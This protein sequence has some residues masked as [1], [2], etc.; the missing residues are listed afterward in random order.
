MKNLKLYINSK[1]C[2]LQPSNLSYNIT[3][4][5]TDYN[6][7]SKRT[8][9]FSYTIKLPRSKTNKQIF[10]FIDDLNVINKF[11]KNKNYECSFYCN[12]NLLIEG[13][14]ILSNWDEGYFNGY[15]TNKISGIFNLFGDKTLQDIESLP[16]I[17]FEGVMFPVVGPLSPNSRTFSTANLECLNTNLCF[18][19]FSLINA[20]KN[21]T[22]GLL[23]S[24]I[25]YQDYFRTPLIAYTNFS[26]NK[27]V[28]G[29][30]AIVNNLGLEDFRPSL[31]LNKVIEKL[32]FDIG[33]TVNIEVPE[34]DD[35]LLIPYVGKDFPD[36]NWTHLSKISV[37]NN[38]SYYN[39]ILKST[40]SIGIYNNRAYY[41]RTPLVNSRTVSLRSTSSLFNY[42]NSKIQYTD[43]A[44]NTDTI[45]EFVEP[46]LNADINDYNKL[47]LIPLNQIN[48]DFNN[49]FQFYDFPFSDYSSTGL[50]NR[51][52]GQIY[53]VPADGKYEFDIS[54][55]HSIKQSHFMDY[56]HY[57]EGPISYGQPNNPDIGVG[58]L[59]TNNY[60]IDYDKTTKGNIVNGYE[61]NTITT[62]T[63]NYIMNEKFYIQNMVLVTKN[64][65]DP[66][67]IMDSILATYKENINQGV[68]RPTKIKTIKR[69][70]NIESDNVVAFYHPMLR[71][72]Y[73]GESGQ[74]TW[75]EFLDNEKTI[76]KQDT[77]YPLT[78][79]QKLTH[80]GFG[81][82]TDILK[83][84]NNITSNYYRFITN[85]YVGI[86]PGTFL[87]PYADQVVGNSSITEQKK[88]KL[89]KMYN[90]N[91]D[92]LLGTTG[93]TGG[94]QLTWE[95][96]AAGQV[97]FK[98]NTLLEKGDQVRMY[99]ITM[100]QF[101]DVMKA[102]PIYDGYPFPYDGKPQYTT[103]G[104][105]YQDFYADE[106][107]VTKFNIKCI[108]EK[109][110]D[111][112]RLANFLPAIKQKDFIQ[113]FIKTNNLYFDIKDNNITFKKRKDFFSKI[114]QKDLT[115]NIDINRIQVSPIENFKTYKYG[116]AP[117]DNDDYKFSIMTTNPPL[118]F[119]NG[120]NIYLNNTTLDLTS[121]IFKSGF[122]T[123]YRFYFYDVIYDGRFKLSDNLIGYP[124]TKFINLTSF[125]ENGTSD[126]ALNEANLTYN[127]SPRIVEYDPSEPFSQP[128][129]YMRDGFQPI[130]INS[131]KFLY[132]SAEIA[133]TN[134]DTGALLNTN[135]TNFVNDTFTNLQDSSYVELYAY[136]NETDYSNLDLSKPVS[137]DSTL[138]YIQKIDSYNP[139]S[140]SLTKI[141]L[142]RL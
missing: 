85:F 89:V 26:T 92:R 2:D 69:M 110:S 74:R 16:Y 140:E 34:L 93:Y 119:D 47:N 98:F 62:G 84:D 77:T 1:L 24:E 115:P 68:D 78:E 81:K 82:N 7:I 118:S 76:Y 59:C 80:F 41:V 91:N 72:L 116:F 27:N 60:L 37:Y 124:S 40:R 125:N 18:D 107:N 43:Y 42:D 63:W 133:N 9:D 86:D 45:G 21:P 129:T 6:D 23:G 137:I 32:F 14:F 71:D 120:N 128:V 121:T 25:D 102:T 33:Y 3:K 141:I 61:N 20:Y 22:I 139:I 103:D 108:D 134:A 131:M 51:N 79:E 105:P 30:K 95:A 111:K 28:L 4:Q 90:N 49:N 100:N 87:Q 58:Y 88:R 70:M 48:Y 57:I 96:S 112:L 38:L 64:V 99:Y 11:N 67:D 138:Y 53:T 50:S 109:Y 127:T 35:N 132:S 46:C 12:D 123:S 13:Y 19:F 29:K 5:I 65:T 142:L 122:D 104:N 66:S 31:R 126:V 73:G 75:E 135:R 130:L 56:R 101:A 52:S 97:D 83:Y 8:G 55:S 114:I 113:D 15:I 17:E 36:W 39:T 117:S 136:L 94:E 44:L 10:K 54:I 106:I